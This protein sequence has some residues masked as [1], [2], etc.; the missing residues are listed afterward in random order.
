M[1]LVEV[2]EEWIQKGRVFLAE[3]EECFK[4]KIYWLT[5]FHAH[6]ATEFFLRA[7]L[8]DKAGSYPFTHDLAI[9]LNDVESMGFDVPDEVYD[10]AEF[11]TPHYLTS[12]YPRRR[13]IEYGERRGLLCLKYS[14]IIVK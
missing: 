8:L 2:V 4:K 14:K 5:C 7:L 12:R 3:A 6:Q 10:A 9:L 11:L 1:G 13:V